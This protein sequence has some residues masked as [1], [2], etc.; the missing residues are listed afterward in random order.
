MRDAARETASALAS[1]PLRRALLAFLA[2]SVAEWACWVA[3]LVWAY[4]GGG[5]GAASVVSV[6]QLV[7]AV[8]VAPVAATLGDRLPRARALALGYL[9]QGVSMLATATVLAAGAGLAAGAATAAAVTCAVTLTRPVH[10][11]ALP[12]LAGTPAR[13]VAGNAATTTAEGIGAFLGPLTCGLLITRGGAELVLAL[14]GA[15][16]LAAA[17]GVATIDAGSARAT[18][19]DEVGAVRTALGG[20]RELAREPA[21]AALLAMVAGQ[22]VVVGAMDILILVLALDVLG[23]DNSGPGLLASALG[24]GGILGGVATVVLVGRRRLAPALAAGLLVTGLPLALLALGGIPAEVAVLL[25][26]SG[27]GHAFFDVAGHTLLQRVVPDAVLARVFGVEEAVMTAALAGGAAL[28]PV[29]VATLGVSGTL[30]ATGALLPVCGAFGWRWLRRLDRLAV[31]PGPH[32]PLLRHIPTLRLVPL[33]M[34]EQLSRDTVAVALSPDEVAVRE[35][36]PGDRLY[37]VLD[38]RL[39][40]SRSGRDVRELGPG[41]SFGEIALLYGTR[42][43][44]TVRAVAPTALVALG[45]EQFLA[46]LGGTGAGRAAAEQVAQAWLEADALA[47]HGSGAGDPA[48]AQAEERTADDGPTSSVAP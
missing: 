37:I 22:Y 7:P 42:R 3:V 47:D 27:A 21:A 13:L 33:P 23:T 25:A 5:V 34:L 31:P 12:A 1:A 4:D 18:D 9:L 2:F 44:A 15:L 11:A 24:V 36:D 10:R 48:A 26:V 43:T 19:E 30:V 17:G 32:L 29:G 46:A 35:G 45:R 39:V 6:A 38:G 14:F 28:A 41:D 20:A 16:M 8:L 40:V